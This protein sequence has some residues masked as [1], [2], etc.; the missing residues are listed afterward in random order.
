MASL[1]GGTS[2]T[3]QTTASRT[4]GSGDIT[5]AS[6]I[7]WTG[8]ASLTLNPVNNLTVNAPITFGGTAGAASLNLIAANALAINANVTVKGIG[9]V[10]LDYA[11]NAVTNLS[12]GNGAALTFANADGSAATSS[13]GGALTIQGG[14]ARLTLIWG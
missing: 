13:A 6:P 1:N 4:G 3:E 8:G 5:V 14:E 11:T 2:V 7:T 12:F 9:A 10:T